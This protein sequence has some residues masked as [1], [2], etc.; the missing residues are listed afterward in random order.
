M[1]KSYYKIKTD[2][3]DDAIERNIR[4]SLNTIENYTQKNIVERQV[5]ARWKRVPRIVKLPRPPH[6]AITSVRTIDDDGTETVLTEGTDYYVIGN[7]VKWVD[8]GGTAS[9][10]LEVVYTAGYGKNLTDIP[11]WAQDAIIFQLGVFYSN[12]DESMGTRV[13]DN[14]LKIDERAVSA[15][16]GNVYYGD[17]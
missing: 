16:K 2:A 8:I 13:Y 3:D 10:S 5:T 7:E 6:G 12:F 17:V 11:T 14:G 4:T 1:V 9:T 15:C